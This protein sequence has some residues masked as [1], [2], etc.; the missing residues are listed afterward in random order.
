[1]FGS[2]KPAETWPVHELGDRLDVLC[3]AARKAGL[4]A[5]GVADILQRQAEAYLQEDAVSVNLSGSPS[6][7]YFDGY[8]R[9][10]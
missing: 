10:L 6:A 3:S 5:A 4:S 8:G 7:K 9:P 1:M 2:K